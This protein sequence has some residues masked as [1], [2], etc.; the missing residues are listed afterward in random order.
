MEE[1]APSTSQNQVAG[2]GA[3]DAGDGKK[4]ADKKKT[5][6]DANKKR[7]K[8][9][10]NK[11]KTKESRVRDAHYPG[12]GERW[13]KNSAERIWQKERLK[14]QILAFKSQSKKEHKIQQF[15]QS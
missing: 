9:N 11:K 13:S 6:N 7:M 5:S 2:A 10:A 1:T 14:E 12:K 15:A 8:K 3:S 4:N